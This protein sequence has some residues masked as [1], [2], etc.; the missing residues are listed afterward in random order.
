MV[1]FIF[2][3]ILTILA[4]RLLWPYIVRWIQAYT[5]RKAEDMIRRMAGMPS[6]AEEEKARK[7]ARKQGAGQSR[8]QQRRYHRGNPEM[9]HRLMKEYAVDAEFTEIKEYSEDLSF[10][11]DNHGNT[12]VRLEEQV[13]DAEYVI[14]K[15]K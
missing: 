2:I 3:L 10:A 7:Q 14:L 4:L 5:A 8:S 1:V 15:S 12:R 13:S 9:A 11:Q 6:R